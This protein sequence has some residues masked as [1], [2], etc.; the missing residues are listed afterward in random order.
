MRF[1]RYLSSLVDTSRHLLR[2]V[3]S[4][5]QLLPHSIQ[6]ESYHSSLVLHYEDQYRSIEMV[7]LSIKK[8]GHQ[9]QQYEEWFDYLKLFNKWISK[10][11]YKDTKQVNESKD[12]KQYVIRHDPLHSSFDKLSQR[13]L[14]YLA[15]VLIKN[16]L[17]WV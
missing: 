8:K 13:Y 1:P 14:L 17:D 9:Q 11:S 3:L 10:V 7:Y 15:I 6:K 4:S 16:Q 5:K 12:N 2:E